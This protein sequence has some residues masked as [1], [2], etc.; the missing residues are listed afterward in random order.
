ME[1][2]NTLMNKGAK[3]TL[4]IPSGLAY[5]NQAIGDIPANSNLIFEV[6]LVDY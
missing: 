1:D 4:Y 5:G 2:R 6:T 3:A